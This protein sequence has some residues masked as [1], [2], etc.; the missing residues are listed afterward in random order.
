MTNTTTKRQPKLH[1][2]LRI[3]A[4]E[5]FLQGWKIKAY[6]YL[7]AACDKGYALNEE[8]QDATD[9]YRKLNGLPEHTWVGRY[10]K[11]EGA[12]AIRKAQ[13][14]YDSYWISQP[15]YLYPFKYGWS[16]REMNELLDKDIIAKRDNL[17]ARTEAKIGKITYAAG[18]MIGYTGELEGVIVGETGKARIETIGAGGYNIQCY[19][20]RML[21]HVLKEKAAK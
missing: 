3:P 9:A 6:D 7:K 8:L 20:Y 17:V 19:H 10:P 2:E 12:D 4:I 11:G 18:L 21:I 13:A 14:E 5:E 15:N 16:E 1:T